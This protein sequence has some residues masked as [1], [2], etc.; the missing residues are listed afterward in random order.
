M[1]NRTITDI[2]DIANEFNI[3]FTTVAKANEKKL[4]SS[5]SEFTYYPPQPNRDAFF[6]DPTTKEDI[7]NEI[8]T[9]KTNKFSGPSSILTKVFKLLKTS[10]SGT[11]SLITNL[12]FKTNTFS[13][14]L[15]QANETSIQE[16]YSHTM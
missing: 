8:E 14:T 6:L 7:Q 13:G 4:V 5:Q 3:H 12:S 9:L 15:D 10:L 1:N 16:R 2:R 11:I